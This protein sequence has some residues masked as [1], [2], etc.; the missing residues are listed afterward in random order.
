MIHAV[1]ATPENVN[2]ALETTVLCAQEALGSLCCQRSEALVSWGYC[3]PQVAPL[4][5]SQAPST[6][7]SSLLPDL[8][9][10]LQGPEPLLEKAQPHTGPELVGGVGEEDKA[11]GVT[12]LAPSRCL[13]A[14]HPHNSPGLSRAQN[15]LTAQCQHVLLWLWKE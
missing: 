12:A 10:A 2:Q 3:S 1:S 9:P 4:R 7:S 14:P 15:F 11:G 8:R 5:L 6:A 13:R